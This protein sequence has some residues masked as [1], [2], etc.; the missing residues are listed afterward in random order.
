MTIEEAIKKYG[1][2]MIL[3]AGIESELGN[4]RVYSMELDAEEFFSEELDLELSD[5]SFENRVI[6]DVEH[7][8]A[9]LAYLDNNS[10]E[11]YC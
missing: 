10:I 9:M 4:V 5:P 2:T 3:Y 1:N 11:Y 8:R 6:I 7:G